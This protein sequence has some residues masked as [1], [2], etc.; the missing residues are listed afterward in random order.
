MLILY[1]YMKPKEP[2]LSWNLLQN[3]HSFMKQDLLL[4]KH[5]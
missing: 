5:T 2:P 1:C 4:L 3:T